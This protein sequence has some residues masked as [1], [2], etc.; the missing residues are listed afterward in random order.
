MSN[1]KDLENLMRRIV[2]R[3]IPGASISVYKDEKPLYE[4]CFGYMDFDRKRPLTPDA[5]FR[6]YSMTKPVS[7]LCGMIQYERG[8]FLMD[9]PVSEYLP[10]YKDLK[11][12]VKQPDGTWT[13]EDSKTPM[14]MR[15]L[16]NMN[17]GFYAHDGSPTDVGMQE[18]NKRLGG[19]KFKAGYDHLTEIRNLPSIPMYFEPGTRWQYG[20][21][22][23]IMAGVV[24]ATS[25]MGLGDFMKKNIF[26][27]LGM[28][29]T[30]YRFREGWQ[31]RVV[32]CVRR[33]KKTG[34]YMKM[35]DAMGD[36]LDLGHMPECKYE[37]ASTG[38]LSTLGDYQ[39]F[40]RMLANGG[41]LN[42]ERIVGR[43][44]IDM[45]RQNLLHD[46]LVKDFYNPNL[47]GYGYGYGVRTLVDP[48]AGL[49]NG[50]VGEFGWCGAAGT[51]MCVD[52]SE[53]LAVTFMQ[54]DF[55][56]D[57][58]YVQHRLRAVINGMLE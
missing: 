44:T 37:S 27:P 51:W 58:H 35:T 47:I 28:N 14:L 10:E 19:T 31:E 17:V 4:G 3:G 34:G 42:G 21:G 50:S 8:V 12:S 36:P 48:V 46:Q 38:L 54:Q 6:M 57:E 5:L 52:P 11:L 49:C 15:H 43:K 9:D 29:D 22:L 26:D 18:M 25:G 20:Y 53:H 16:F 30:W 32:D 24:E 55:I 13:V 45:M 7:A 2:D 1:A 39:K 40:C 56:S 33:D 23:D 41:E